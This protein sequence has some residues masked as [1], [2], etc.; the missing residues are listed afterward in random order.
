[1]DWYC[2][3]LVPVLII[4]MHVCDHA[5]WCVASTKRSTIGQPIARGEI[6][7]GYVV[8]WWEYIFQGFGDIYVKRCEAKCDVVDK[9]LPVG[10]RSTM[11]HVIIDYDDWDLGYVP[12]SKDA[13]LYIYLLVDFADTQS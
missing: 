1:M 5:K 6:E 2:K 13:E 9:V 7:P 8:H 10:T 3:E 12:S 11:S 4:G